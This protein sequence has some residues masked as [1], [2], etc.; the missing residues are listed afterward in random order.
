MINLKYVSRK[1]CP[2]FRPL[3]AFKCHIKCTYTE[4]ISYRNVHIKYK[5]Q[6]SLFGHFVYFVGQ[7]RNHTKNIIW[8]KNNND[9]RT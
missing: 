6:Q 2:L 3:L 8:T 5:W 4:C 1:K 7:T 9:E